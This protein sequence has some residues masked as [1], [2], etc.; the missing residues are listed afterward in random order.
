MELFCILHFPFQ[1]KSV[2]PAGS[3][4]FILFTAFIRRVPK[5]PCINFGELVCRRVVHKACTLVVTRTVRSLVYCSTERMFPGTFTPWN[6][7]YQWELSLRGAKITGS[8][9]SLNPIFCDPAAKVFIPSDL[10]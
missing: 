5:R 1:T 8:E 3:A 4:T 2:Y 7:S 6:E 10:F 9:K